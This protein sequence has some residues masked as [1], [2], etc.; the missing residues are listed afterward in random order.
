[1]IIPWISYQFKNK[2]KSSSLF[3]FGIVVSG[4]LLDE[5]S[6]PIAAKMLVYLS[7]TVP[8]NPSI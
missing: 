7:D 1:M 2:Q 6:A 5:A 8:S 3:A 4:V